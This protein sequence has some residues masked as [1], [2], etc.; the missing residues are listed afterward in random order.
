M[1]ERIETGF[2]DEKHVHHFAV[3]GN[4]RGP[5]PRAAGSIVSTARRRMFCRPSR[6]HRGR[7]RNGFVEAVVAIIR[8]L[9][10]PPRFSD[11]EQTAEARERQSPSRAATADDPRCREQAPGWSVA[12]PKAAPA[13]LTAPTKSTS[14]SAAS[15][16]PNHGDIAR[17][18]IAMELTGTTTLPPPRVPS[19]AT[20]TLYAPDFISQSVVAKDWFRPRTSVASSGGGAPFLPAFQ[21]TGRAVT[22]RTPPPST[23]ILI[24]A[25]PGTTPGGRTTT[26]TGYAPALPS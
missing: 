11:R 10:V 12:S 8:V 15:I 21:N 2:A 16:A 13:I 23:R 26:R 1:R 18:E 19:T 6:A 9:P 24:S 5:S 17:R 14:P 20:S 22:R 25:S 4:E 7:H 3:V